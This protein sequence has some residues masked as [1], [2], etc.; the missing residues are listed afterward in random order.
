MS[1]KATI[2]MMINFSY[3]QVRFLNRQGYLRYRT[4]VY[5]RLENKDYFCHP[6]NIVK[7][8]TK[9]SQNELLRDNEEKIDSEIDVDTMHYYSQLIPVRYRPGN[10]DEN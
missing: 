2:D 5:I 4:R 1:F 7:G 8:P 6:Y 10:Y 9:N 3:I